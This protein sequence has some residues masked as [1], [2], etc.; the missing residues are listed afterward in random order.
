MWEFQKFN[1]LISME[2]LG[3]SHVYK[4]NWFLY[5]NFTCISVEVYNNTFILETGERS[6]EFSLPS[7]M[8]VE[9]AGG[10]E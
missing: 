9:A 7:N 1:N 2:V 5:A 4:L 10:I 8:A 3:F 6:T